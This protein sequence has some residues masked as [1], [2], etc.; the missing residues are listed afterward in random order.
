MSLHSYTA[1][2]H[3]RVKFTRSADKQS[4][5]D[6]QTPARAMALPIRHNHSLDCFF[7]QNRV[8][9]ID[10]S[11]G[12]GQKDHK[13][14]GFLL[15]LYSYGVKLRILLIPIKPFA[16]RLG[17]TV[18]YHSE[19]RYSD[20]HKLPRS[21]GAIQKTLAKSGFWPCCQLGLPS[22]MLPKQPAEGIYAGPLKNKVSC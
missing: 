13:N 21:C 10:K 4:P 6:R 11:I 19:W 3:L 16:R 5:K 17:S 20:P 9:E 14:R 15:G 18:L 2:S 8:N 22:F 12:F 7:G 1:G